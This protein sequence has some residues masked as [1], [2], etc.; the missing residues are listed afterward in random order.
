[1]LARTKRHGRRL[2]RG[3]LAIARGENRSNCG[4]ARASESRSLLSNKINA[5]IKFLCAPL[6]ALA[7]AS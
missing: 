6:A 7:F 2:R 1:L 5:G 3:V 4:E